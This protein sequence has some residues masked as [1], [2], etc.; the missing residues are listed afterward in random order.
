MQRKQT[1]TR[2]AILA[3]ALGLTLQGCIEEAPP[4]LVRPDPGNILLRKHLDGEKKIAQ[5]PDTGEIRLLGVPLRQQIAIAYDVH[6]RDVVLPGGTQGELL[7]DSWARPA[8]GKSETSRSLLAK[9][10][11]GRLGL[12]GEIETKQMPAVVIRQKS[13]GLLQ[14]SNSPQ[15]HVETGPGFFRASGAPMR[16]LTRFVRGISARPV[17]DETGLTERYDMVFEWDPEAEAHAAIATF[18]DLGLEL[19]FEDRP[20]EQLVV[21]RVQRTRPARPPKKEETPS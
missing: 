3:M 18:E 2:I 19:S 1:R 20:V 12:R 9:I 4:P 17:V 21:K 6:P 7:L 16:E 15:S 8:D 5:R 11:E 13:E 10:I 14:P